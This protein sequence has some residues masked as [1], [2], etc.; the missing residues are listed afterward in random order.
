MNLFTGLSRTDY[1]DLFRAIGALI[2]EHGLH[3]VRL[4][5]HENGLVL[6]GES[7]PGASTEGM[8][9]TT[10]LTDADLEAL[11]ADSYQRR[12]AG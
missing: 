9:Q 7:A 1:Q 3:N 4:W 6:Q 2:D 12:S 11:L 10:L 5:E 8:F